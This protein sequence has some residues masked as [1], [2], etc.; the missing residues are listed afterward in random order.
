MATLRPSDSNALPDDAEVPGTTGE[1][2]P[3]EV[4]ATL[5]L[6]DSAQSIGGKLYLLGGGWSILSWS[7][8]DAKF[9]V[10]LAIKLAIPWSQA[11][12][13][14]EVLARLATEDGE[15]VQ[16][17]GQPIE[18]RGEIEVGRPA[19][20]RPGTPLDVP[21]AMNINNLPLTPGGYR[22]ELLVG[23]RPVARQPFQVVDRRQT[24]GPHQPG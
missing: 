20:L 16:P 18:V 8:P 6:C 9:N 11:N 15:P 7:G 19:G 5:L 1:G 10:A 3:T 14:M 21:L 2:S 13:R 17:E 12:E 24:A 4:A 23:G 22:W